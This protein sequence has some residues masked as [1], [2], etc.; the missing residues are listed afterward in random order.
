M[1]LGKNL[2]YYTQFVKNQYKANPRLRY[3]Y[4]KDVKIYCNKVLNNAEYISIETY[5]GRE[6]NET[7]NM[8]SLY[9]LVQTK[10]KDCEQLSRFQS[11]GRF[12]LCEML[13]LDVC[14]FRQ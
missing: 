13:V 11:E 12:N 5:V 8:A 6:R 10:T 14:I 2:F 9:R 1:Q 7:D 3:Y 4:A